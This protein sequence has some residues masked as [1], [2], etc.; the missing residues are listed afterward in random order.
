MTAVTLHERVAARRAVDVNVRL[1][2]LSVLAAPFFALGWLIGG[3]VSAVLWVC[4]AIAEGF[5]SG[6]GRVGDLS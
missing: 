2:L 1:V 3:F 5:D 6:R 4:A